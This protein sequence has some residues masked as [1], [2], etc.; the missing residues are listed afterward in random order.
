MRVDFAN[1]AA[2]YARHRTGF[3]DTLFDRLAAHGIGRPGQSVVDLGTGT[4]GLARGFAQR[5]ARV[6]GIDRAPELL[7]EARRLDREADVTIEYRR[8][9]AEATGLP[10]AC[11]DV[12][13]AAQCWHW[14]DRGTAMREVAR[15]LRPHGCLVI[16]HFDWIPVAGSLA[17]ATERLIKSYNWRWR[18]G[19]GNGMHPR[20]LTELGN[21]GYQALESFSYDA[22]V[23]YTPDAWRG[24]VRATAGVGASLSARRVEAFDRALA[25]LLATRYPEGAL[26]VTHRVFAVLARRPTFP[27]LPSARRGLWAVW[28]SRR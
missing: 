14:F 5:G 20:W 7:E 8:A 19:G 24:R 15:L 9:P 25:S 26:A 22:E 16:V 11:A 2:D 13:S 23:R 3:P 27:A 21:A 28:R 6:T 10:D 12:V 17:E 4:G 1:T 18:L